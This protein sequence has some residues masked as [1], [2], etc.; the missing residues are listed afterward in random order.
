MPVSSRR[1]GPA[2]HSAGF[3]SPRRFR[4]PVGNARTTS[5][6]V[7]TSCPPARHSLACLAA[8]CHRPTF[9]SGRDLTAPSS[10]HTPP[11]G[12]HSHGT[13]D[14][15]VGSMLTNSVQQPSELVV[16]RAP[17][18][19]CAI[20]PR[21]TQRVPIDVSSRRRDH[22]QGLPS[23]LDRSRGGDEPESTVNDLNSSGHP[24]KDRPAAN[25]Q[26]A[27]PERDEKQTTETGIGGEVDYKTQRNKDEKTIDESHHPPH[28]ATESKLILHGHSHGLDSFAHLLPS[29]RLPPF[30][31]CP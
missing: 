14:I 5:F 26:C 1:A 27:N 22:T 21:P 28:A 12:A 10:R 25:E 3:C 9:R 18:A 24:K 17:R 4:Y 20:V 30:E 23:D 2:A 15:G 11:L 31:S 6:L 7:A 8:R 13:T 16:V 29:V 19:E